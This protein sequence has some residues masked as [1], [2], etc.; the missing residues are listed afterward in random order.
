[1]IYSCP[2]C[3]KKMDLSD[4]ALKNSDYKI[5]CPQC[6]CQY[7]ADQTTD[8]VQ[9]APE[10]NQIKVI[11]PACIKKKYPVRSST[12]DDVVRYLCGEPSGIVF[13]HGKAGCGKTYVINKVLRQIHGCQVLTPTN[14]AASLYS[15][16]RTLHSFFYGAFD[17]LEEGFQNPANATKARCES[18]SYTLRSLSMLIID[19]V[20]MV[21]SDM[22]EMINR[23]CQNA[24]N[25]DRPFGGLTIVLTGDMFQLPP[26]V[27][28][29]ATLAYLM[30]EYNGIYFFNSH[31]IQQEMG[32]IKL[33]ELTKS[34]RQ[35]QDTGYEKLL[36]AFRE[37]MNLQEKKKIIEQLNRRVTTDFPDDAIYL[38]PTNEAVRQMNGRKLNEL[39]GEITT[40]YARYAVRKKGTEK[41]YVTLSHEELETLPPE[42]MSEIE[43]IILPSAFDSQLQFKKGARVM[44]TK[45]SKPGKYLNGQ[46]GTITGFNGNYFTIRKDKSSEVVMC[47]NPSDRWKSGQMTDYRYEMVYD[48][49]KRRLVRKGHYIQRTN[50]YPLKLAYAFTIHKAQGQTYEKLILDLSSHIFAPGQLYVALSRVKSL[51]GLYLTKP[52]M[53]SDIITDNA[54]VDFLNSLRGFNAGEKDRVELAYAK[55]PELSSPA[56][57]RLVA[58]IRENEEDESLK[59]IL[60]HLLGTSVLLLYNDQYKDAYAELRKVAQAIS[61]A[62]QAGDINNRL[63]TLP[64]TANS[65]EECQTTL[66]LI[67]DLYEQI[68]HFPAKVY[69]PDH[70]VVT[71][72]L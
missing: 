27:S 3:G 55:A 22:M 56:T 26:I 57:D 28:D 32:N 38:A 69:Q 33:F 7:L 31:I 23:I 37:P 29:E 48:S 53:H 36:D 8:D 59:E 15:G 20:S 44:F 49:E 34:F 17:D 42:K 40:L 25:D 24:R 5:V 65:L 39:P 2:H 47:P 60:I 30:D 61:S 1:M 12:Q 66:N 10:H 35:Q 46:F 14:L 54:I 70:K 11:K 16:A 9:P 64:L 4:E 63:E 41:E 52:I 6:L 51:Q 68:L 18:I 13:I 43:H 19:E 50:Q 58:L 62:Y 67:I 45:N 72:K 71:F 21:R